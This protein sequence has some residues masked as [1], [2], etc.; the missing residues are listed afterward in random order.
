MYHDCDSQVTIC[1]NNSVVLGVAPVPGMLCANLSAMAS[2]PAFSTPA[3][4]G[5]MRSRL[6]TL[7]QRSG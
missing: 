1:A 3:D 4:R 2:R 7:L 5:P 6:V